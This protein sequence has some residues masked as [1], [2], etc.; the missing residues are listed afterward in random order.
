MK[1]EGGG[2]EK[3]KKKKEDEEGNK[4]IPFGVMNIT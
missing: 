2:G 3:K 4:R 1:G